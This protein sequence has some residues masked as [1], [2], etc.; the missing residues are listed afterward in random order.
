MYP[1]WHPCILRKSFRTNESQSIW[2]VLDPDMDM[3]G[4]GQPFYRSHSRWTKLTYGSKHMDYAIKANPFKREAEIRNLGFFVL[5]KNPTTEMIRFLGC[6]LARPCLDGKLGKANWSRTLS[7]HLQV[8]LEQLPRSQWLSDI[9]SFVLQKKHIKTRRSWSNFIVHQT[10]VNR[11]GELSPKS[12]TFH[13]RSLRIQGVLKEN[14]PVFGKL[15]WMSSYLL[16]LY[17]LAIPYD[18]CHYLRNRRYLINSWMFFFR[19][20]KNPNIPEGVFDKRKSNKK[21]LYASNFFG[22]GTFPYQKNII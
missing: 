6:R 9:A 11:M 2:W 17:G 16:Q 1:R 15:S 3:S 4:L 20:I 14:L 18:C 10:W 5:P 7:P 13:I 12:F 22:K 21:E 19:G 8:I